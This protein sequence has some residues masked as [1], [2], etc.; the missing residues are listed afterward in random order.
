MRRLTV[1]LAGALAGRR[2]YRLL[3]SGEV[4]VAWGAGPDSKLRSGLAPQRYRGLPAT[5]A[6]A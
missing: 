2:A 5:Q 1:V 4:T 3:A 6:C